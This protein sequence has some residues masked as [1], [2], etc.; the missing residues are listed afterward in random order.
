MATTSISEVR[1]SNMALSRIGA[2]SSIESMT[3]SSAEARECDLWY[4]FSLKQALAAHDWTFARKRLT[5][6]T[7]SEDPPSGVWA[8]RYQYPSDC[9]AF[10][11]IQNP[12]G[13]A[14]DPIPYELEMDAGEDNLS[15]LTDL[16][17]AIGVYTFEQTNVNTFSEHFVMMMALALATNIAYALTSK[18]E[19]EEQM[20]FRFAQMAAAAP[21]SN[22]NEEQRAAPRDAD[23]IRGRQ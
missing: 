10:R 23:T 12:A 4:F 11:K 3:E 20:A 17:D 14:A 18:R 2:D 19:L 16:D 22:A 15:I 7:H 5:L 13:E 21:A 8:Y 1:I 6:T 9:I